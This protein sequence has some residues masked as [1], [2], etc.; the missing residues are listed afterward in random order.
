MDFPYQFYLEPYLSFD[1]WNYLNNDD[2]LDEVSTPVT[3]TVL[4]RIN[5]KLGLNIGVPIHDSFKGIVKVEAFN[6]LDRYINGDVFISTDT[7]DQLKLSGY[8]VG[9]S[10]SMNNL[11]RRQYAS[12][13][14]NMSLSA[15]TSQ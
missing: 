12:S 7:L 11:N 8:K 9:L 3:P 6:S 13:G 10:V 5:R 14:K 4:R 15:I 1:G 2:L